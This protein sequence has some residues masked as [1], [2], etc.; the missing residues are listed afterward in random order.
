[1]NYSIKTN[2][3]S[4]HKDPNVEQKS[5]ILRATPKELKQLEQIQEIRSELYLNNSITN[6]FRVVFH[7]FN[8]AEYKKEFRNRL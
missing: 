8:I 3:H 5:V 6:A 7:Y 2:Y 4:T 1:M